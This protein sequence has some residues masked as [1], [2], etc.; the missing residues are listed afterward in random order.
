MKTLIIRT[1]SLL[2]IPLGIAVLNV[3]LSS[4][5]YGQQDASKKQVCKSISPARPTGGA[6]LQRMQALQEC[7]KNIPQNPIQSSVKED[8]AQSNTGGCQITPA[9]PTGGGTMLRLE[10]I[11]RCRMGVK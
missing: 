7:Y 8:S 4:T 5:A 3:S 2:A 9:R 1:A 6:T 10:A 11:Q